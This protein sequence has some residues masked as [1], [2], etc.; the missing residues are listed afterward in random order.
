MVKYHYKRAILRYFWQSTL[1]GYARRARPLAR[2]HQRVLAQLHIRHDLRPRPALWGFGPGAGDISPR[3]LVRL[4]HTGDD[5]VVLRL[6]LYA[7]TNRTLGTGGGATEGGNTPKPRSGGGRC[8]QRWQRSARTVTRPR[9]RP[10]SRRRR[11]QVPSTKRLRSPIS[12]ACVL[13]CQ[14]NVRD[15]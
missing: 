9:A 6:R 8:S 12:R 14:P 7:R 15:A 1:E 11:T 5:V 13:R 4:G 2:T 10:R 3:A